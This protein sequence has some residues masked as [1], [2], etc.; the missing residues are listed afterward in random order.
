M[1]PGQLIALLS[2]I[3]ISVQVGDEKSLHLKGF[4]L[5][6]KYFE[7]FE[8]LSDQLQQG[9][10]PASNPEM[11]KMDGANA[12]YG[13]KGNFYSIYTIIHIIKK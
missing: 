4:D 10:Q 11:L 6:L 3:Y 1:T 7:I 5:V 12:K 9:Q 2:L 13:P 8:N